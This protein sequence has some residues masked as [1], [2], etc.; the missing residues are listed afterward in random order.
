MK[1]NM[2]HVWDKFKEVYARMEMRQRLMVAI[3]LAITFGI[4]IWMI[5]WSAKTEYGLLFSRLSYEDARKTITRLDEMRIPWRLRDEGSSIFIPADKVYETRI[6]LS[7][8][9]IGIM[10]TGV[11]FEIFDRTTL[12]TTEFVQKTVNWARANAGEIER[13]LIT[14]VGVEFVRVHLVFPEERLFREDQQEPSASVVLHIQRQHRIAPRTIDGVVN[15]IASSVAGL[16]PDRITIIDQDGRLLSRHEDDSTIGISNQQISI[17]Q[18]YETRLRSNVMSL[19]DPMFGMGN[20]SVAI[21]VAVNFDQRRSTSERWDPEGQVVRSEQIMTDNLTN[22]SDSLATVSER[23]VT[24]YEISSTVSSIEHQTGDIKRLT[25]A[26]VVNYKA[27]TSIVD[28]R[29]E[30]VWVPRTMEELAHIEALVKGAVG[31]NADRGDNVTVASIPFDSTTRDD[32][33]LE[34]ERQE[35]IKQYFEWGEK[36]AVLVVLIVLL[37]MLMSQFK[38]IFAKP[39]PEPELDEIEELIEGVGPAIAAVESADGV[40]AEEGFYPEG[41]EGMPM[42]EGKISFTLRPMKDIAIE[43]TEAML[44]V[45]T[46]QK[47]VIENP[48]VT[49]KLLKTWM[50]DERSAKS[51]WG[52]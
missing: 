23:F 27:E 28:G 43:Q 19:L 45:E 14:I 49:V 3:L 2:V 18:Q 22:L 10:H 13:S 51:K 4:I 33:R 29:R 17:Q 11:G 52:N 21:S 30:T 31:F 46:I 41:D 37:M 26:T 5:S 25:V 15:F 39:E 9:N 40:T 12:G 42:G 34:F 44:L 38:K 20:T 24:N 16:S 47:F 32:E 6:N 7:T 1:E 36:L 48:E 35:R 8:E 50:M